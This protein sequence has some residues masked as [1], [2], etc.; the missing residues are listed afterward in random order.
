[1]LVA[2]KNTNIP[3]TE[4]KGKKTQLTG[5]MQTYKLQGTMQQY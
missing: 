5:T 1:M 4:N 3:V 2:V